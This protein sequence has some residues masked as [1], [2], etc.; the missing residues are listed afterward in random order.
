M[1]PTPTS[2]VFITHVRTD[3][4][5]IQLS[6]ALAETLEA[7]GF[8][9]WTEER[10]PP[11]ADESQEVEK[12]LSESDAMIAL[13]SQ[14]SYSSVYVRNELEYAFFDERYKNR[15]LPVLIGSPEKE[16]FSRLPWVLT[17]MEYLRVNAALPAEETAERIAQCFTALLG[18]GS[19]S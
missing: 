3:K 9:V 2:R 5:L 6:R 15:L 14:H 13:L 19:A 16:D 10:I 4:D 1:Q 8:K 7:Q 11:D 18:M 12:A 17:K